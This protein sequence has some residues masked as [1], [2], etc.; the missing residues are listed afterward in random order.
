M[1]NSRDYE[2]VP[3]GHCTLEKRAVYACSECA[4]SGEIE[5]R[6]LRSLETV[7]NLVAPG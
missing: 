1:G 7:E 2:A 4:S 6:F 5:E 3:R